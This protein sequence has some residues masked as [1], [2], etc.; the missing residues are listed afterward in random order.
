MRVEFGDCVFDGETR[1]LVRGGKPAHLS[2]KA[3]SL[4]ELLLE[5]RPRV[6]SKAEIHEKV[7]PGTFV[8]DATLASAIAEIREALGDAGRK[9]HFI[10]TVHAYG[11]GFS[12][13]VAAAAGAA[14]SAEWAYRLVWDKRE[15]ALDDGENVLGRDRDAL[16]WIDDASVSRRHARITV[17]RQ[18]ATIQDLESKNGTFLRGQP[19]DGVVPLAN[20]DEIRLGSVTMTFRVLPVIGSTVTQSRL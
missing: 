8:S 13:D 15:I 5:N 6:L 2:P 9:A 20:G 3:F 17:S 4:L 12:G 19:V 10:R 14:D 18:G 1:Q 16:I 11:Y 7:W